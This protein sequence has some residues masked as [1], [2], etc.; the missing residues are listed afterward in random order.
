MEFACQ[1]ILTE[2][3]EKSN[4]CFCKS[5]CP[6]TKTPP[7]LAGGADGFLEYQRPRKA[8]VSEEIKRLLA[9]ANK[10]ILCF[11]KKS[12]LNVV[13]FFRVYFLVFK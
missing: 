1:M 9:F 6:D 8:S 7:E 11:K 5:F 3:K 12:I 13:E 10:T 4:N 2:R